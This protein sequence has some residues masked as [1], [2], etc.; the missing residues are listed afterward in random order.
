MSTQ[1]E[2]VIPELTLGQ[3]LTVAMEHA[4]YKPETL[5]PQLRCS[6]TTIR[7]YISARTA[8]DYA[9]LLLWAT[10]CGVDPYWLEIGTSGPGDPGPGAS[11]VTGEFRAPHRSRA[12]LVSLAA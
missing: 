4:G 7:N 11:L 9:H 6:A 2:G 5:A 1:T 12:P 3:R 8:I 10:V